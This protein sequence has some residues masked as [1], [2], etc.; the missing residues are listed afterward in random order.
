MSTFD[1]KQKNLI[2]D[3]LEGCF[4]DNDPSDESLRIIYLIPES[5]DGMHAKDIIRDTEELT[6]LGCNVYVWDLSDRDAIEVTGP[7]LLVREFYA[8]AYAWA[9]YIT[10][11]NRGF[12]RTGSVVSS[13]KLN[14][15]AGMLRAYSGVTYSIPIRPISVLLKHL[16]T[17]KEAETKPQVSGSL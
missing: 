6:E 15:S 4:A 2:I 7:E 9:D 11:P 8:L 17:Q 13:V 10:I 16:K 12:A 5:Y 14:G 1:I 3:L